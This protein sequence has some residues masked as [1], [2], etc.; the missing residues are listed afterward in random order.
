[1]PSRAFHRGYR[2]VFNRSGR[3]SFCLLHTRLTARV[4]SAEDIQLRI[5]RLNIGIVKWHIGGVDYFA[6]FTVPDNGN[7]VVKARRT[8]KVTP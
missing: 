6:R 5:C 2:I 8:G 4:L 3:A 7:V 1:V